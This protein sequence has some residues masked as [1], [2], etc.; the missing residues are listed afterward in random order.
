MNE[1]MTVVE[2]IIE[3]ALREFSR[4]KHLAL[5][6]ETKIFGAGGLLD[7][8]NFVGFLM[9]IEALLKP[10][11][12]TPVRLLDNK[13]FARHDNPFSTVGS[14]SAYIGELLKD[15]GHG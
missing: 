7:S 2:Q 12:K 6:D 1:S 4:A 3:P 13:A 11:A 10:M 14:L 9:E 5:N 15:T 8:I